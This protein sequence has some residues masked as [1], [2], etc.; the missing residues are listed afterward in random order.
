MGNIQRHDY[1]AEAM[2]RVLAGEWWIKSVVANGYMGGTVY[3]HHWV[4]YQCVLKSQGH[5]AQY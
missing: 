1:K 5:S 3:T 2:L 4:D